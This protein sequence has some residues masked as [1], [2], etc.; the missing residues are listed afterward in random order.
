MSDSVTSPA[1]RLSIEELNERRRAVYRY[2]AEWLIA[3]RAGAV[4]LSDVLR[5]AET[6]EGA[7]LMMLSLREVLATLPDMSS[8]KATHII[9]RTLDELG[10][11]EK[12]EKIKVRWVMNQ[13]SRRRRVVALADAMTRSHRTSPTETWP[14]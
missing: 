14:W 12:P 4:T 3:L 11:D 6:V 13:R 1:R 5:Q 7:P 10:I 2:R 8:A 9:R